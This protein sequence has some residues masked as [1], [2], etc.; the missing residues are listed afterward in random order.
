MLS[1][2]TLADLSPT[3]LA[4][5][6]QQVGNTPLYPIR[7]RIHGKVR[8]V[9]LKLETENPTHSMKDRT[10]YSLIQQYEESGLL[11]AGS[12]VVESTSGNLGVALAFICKARGYQ[13]IAVVDPK[14]TQENI[15][16]M[17]SFG[18]RMEFV[19]RFDIHN[20][21]LLTRLARVQELCAQNEEYV[22]TNQYANKM[23]PQIHYLETGPEIYRQMLKKVDVIFVPVSTGGT[24]TGIGR[25]FREVSP[26]TTII[27]VDAYGSVIFG[28]PAAARKLTG[29]GASRPSNFVTR[30]I[31]D[32]YM[33]VRDE[34]AF[35]FCHALA[36]KTGLKLGGS[37]GC[38]LFA[39][40]QFLAE[41]ANETNIVCVCAD[42]GENYNSTIYNDAWIQQYPSDLFNQHL[43]KYLEIVL[44]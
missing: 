26:A 11:S 35:A 29:I 23:N 28:T 4:K 37:S 43:E 38:V 22:W 25:Y 42:S 8:T 40:A 20:G 6:V 16:R 12:T 44:A 30:D 31:Y 41:H 3:E 33:L 18:A 2:N 1:F 9:H 34:E 5:L 32:H 39:C 24:L 7:L 13:F 17:K 27:G 36:I 19:D 21:Y 14:V 10:G 15:A